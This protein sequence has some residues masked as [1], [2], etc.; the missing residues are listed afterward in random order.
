[1]RRVPNLCQSIDRHVLPDKTQTSHFI[2]LGDLQLSYSSLYAAVCTP[3][4]IAIDTLVD[5][6]WYWRR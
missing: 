6:D 3:R 1:M 4:C 2:I 5:L